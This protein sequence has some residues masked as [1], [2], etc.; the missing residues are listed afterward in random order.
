LIYLFDVA[1]SPSEMIAGKET[2]KSAFWRDFEGAGMS[3]CAI[4]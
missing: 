3:S 2:E 1:F 4:V